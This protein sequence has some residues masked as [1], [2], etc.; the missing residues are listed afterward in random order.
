MFNT[1][2]CNLFCSV[3][4]CDNLLV[5]TV[6]LSACLS[7]RNFIGFNY[8]FGINYIRDYSDVSSVYVNVVREIRDR[9][10]FIMVLIHTN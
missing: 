4:N 5:S 7:C 8:Q 6:F 10:S 2:F 1:R 9:S 3:C